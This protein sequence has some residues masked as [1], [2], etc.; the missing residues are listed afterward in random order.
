MLRVRLLLTKWR[1]VPTPSW[2]LVGC[3]LFLL[4]I[5]VGEYLT[6]IDSLWLYTACLG[7]FLLALVWRGRRL[8]FLICILGGVLFFGLWRGQIVATKPVNN[9]LLNYTQSVERAILVGRV[10]DEPSLSKGRQVVVLTV[11]S[12]AGQKIDAGKVSLNIPVWPAYQWGQT[13]SVRCSLGPVKS[14]QQAR[15]FWR[16]IYAY[17]NEP[18]IVVTSDRVAMNSWLGF[19]INLRQYLATKTRDVLSEPSASLLLGI[20]LGER[21]GWSE[22]FNQDF[23]NVGLSHITAISGSNISIVMSCLTGVLAYLLVRRRYA[24]WIIGLSVGFFVL[25]TGGTAATVRAAVMG[26]VVS[27]ASLLGRKVQSHRILTYVLAV[28]LVLDPLAWHYDVGFQ[29]SFL[30]VVGMIYVAPLLDEWSRSWMKSDFWR[31]LITQTAAAL[32]LTTPW[33]LVIFGRVSL[34]APVANLLVLPLIPLLM[35]LG[36]LWLVLLPL[37][38]W[39]GS[40]F[41]AFVSFPVWL[42]LSYVVVVVEFLAHWPISAMSGVPVWLSLSFSVVTYGAMGWWFWRRHSNLEKLP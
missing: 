5:V 14:D 29:L 21:G 8:I 40:W 9:V 4:G 37:L 12:V 17:C 23:A 27:G 24:W 41:T 36:A 35:F 18:D 7:C 2:V 34:V 15:S 25:L 6:F 11:D 31:L 16:H 32:L 30:A 1:D 26:L 42:A 39:L 20:M 19:I 10:L 33:I 13:W 28:M 3:W 38:A 22:S